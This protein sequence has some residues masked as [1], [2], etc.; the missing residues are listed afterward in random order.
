MRGFLNAGGNIHLVCCYR[1]GAD[2][3]QIVSRQG[4]DSRQTVSRQEENAQ[5]AE[6]HRIYR[7]YAEI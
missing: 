2:S 3:R 5:T 7:V 1:L 6:R 4:A